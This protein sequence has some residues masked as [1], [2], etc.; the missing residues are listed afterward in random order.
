MKM[1][2]RTQQRT[3]TGIAYP[4]LR[5]KAVKYW[6]HGEARQETIVEAASSGSYGSPDQGVIV[7][8]EQGNILDS[9]NCDFLIKD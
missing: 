1:T 2:Q 3:F 4:H 9:L 8:T 5:G 6:E 7:L